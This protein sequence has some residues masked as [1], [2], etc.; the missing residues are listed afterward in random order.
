MKSLT[1]NINTRRSG[2]VG[3]VCGILSAVCYG[4][5]PLGAL[6]LYQEGENTS[7]VLFFRFL[8]A[9]ILLGSLLAVRRFCFVVNRH[10]LRVLALLGVLFAGSSIT[11]YQ[12][13]H[14][15]EIGRAHV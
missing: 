7:S 9:V 4:T 3:I 14:F 11:Y 13:F 12:S 15:M 1:D 10:Q 5:N 8:M 6:P 2:I